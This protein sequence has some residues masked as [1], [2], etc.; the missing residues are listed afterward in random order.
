MTKE[1]KNEEEKTDS[2]NSTTNIKHLEWTPENE[3]IMIEW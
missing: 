3:Y 1:E 2:G